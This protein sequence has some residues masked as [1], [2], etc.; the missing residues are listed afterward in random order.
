[1][2]RTRPFEKREDS[3]QASDCQEGKGTAFGL[4]WGLLRQAMLKYQNN[5]WEGKKSREV[6]DVVRGEPSDSGESL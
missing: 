6:G 3:K 4:L 1:M 5:R 2:G